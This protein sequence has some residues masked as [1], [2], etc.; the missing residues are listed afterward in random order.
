ME[1][2][3]QE[4]R[5]YWS[6][7]FRLRR[8]TTEYC[9]INV[10]VTSDLMIPQPDGTGRLDVNR[11]VQRAAEISQSAEVKWYVEKKEV[12]PHPIQKPMDPGEERFQ[13]PFS[14]S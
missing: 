13:G 12:G 1:P 6:V 10:P 11:M 5:N 3:E 14:E 7:Q 8:V 4:E 9:Y 2:E